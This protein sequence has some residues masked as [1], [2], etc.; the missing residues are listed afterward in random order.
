MINAKIRYLLLLATLGAFAAQG[1][2]AAELVLFE[3]AGCVWCEAWHAEIGGIYP[4]TAE[5]RIAPLRRVDVHAQRPTD[6]A[7]VA[8]IIYTPTFVLMDD[9]EEIGRITGYA[10]EEFFWGLLG[11]ELKKLDTRATAVTR[12]SG[13]S[14]A[15][16]RQQG[17]NP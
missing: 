17:E 12:L 3:S 10:G 2:R 1:S 7:A 13:T 4:K 14:Q 16:H 9:G 8:R 15:P 11:V 5:S 6:L